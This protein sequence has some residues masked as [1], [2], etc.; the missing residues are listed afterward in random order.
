MEKMNYLRKFKY[1][2]MCI[3][4]GNTVE[5]IFGKKIKPLATGKKGR[6]T[7][8]L[9]YLTQDENSTNAYVSFYDRGK[10]YYDDYHDQ[11]YNKGHLYEMY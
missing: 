1:A 3:N 5:S 11:D 8:A 7:T 9:V 4:N 6:I 2:Q 10:I